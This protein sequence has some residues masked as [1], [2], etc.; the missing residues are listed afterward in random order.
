M[1][2]GALNIAIIPARAG[3]KGVPGKNYR[4]INGKPLVAWSIEAAIACRRIDLIIVSSNCP[5]VEKVTRSYDCRRLHFLPR[6]DEIADDFS[7][8]EDALVHAVK[9]V[10]R[11]VGLKPRWVTLLQPT[12]PVRNLGLLHRCCNAVLDQQHWDS[13]LTTSQHTPFFYRF[14]EGGEALATGHCPCDRPMRQEMDPQ[15]DML[16]HDAGNVFMTNAELLLDTYCRIGNTPYLQVI[17]NY[18]AWQIDREEDFVIL[19][20]MSKSFGSFI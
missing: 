18:Q 1:K 15:R 6:P 19:E 8:T 11:D 12:S 9:Y 14:G 4:L 10:M 7:L 16:Y 3:S 17:D 5:E 2:G 20:A 13:L